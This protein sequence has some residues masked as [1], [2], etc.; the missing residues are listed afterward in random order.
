MIPVST[1]VTTRIRQGLPRIPNGAPWPPVTETETTHA[2]VA[3]PV[4]AA[5]AAPAAVPAQ[6][7]V[8]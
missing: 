4:A 8:S 3:A 5:P 2:P 1:T 7:A 6:V